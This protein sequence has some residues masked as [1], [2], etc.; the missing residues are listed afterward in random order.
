[1][2]LQELGPRRLLQPIR[3]WLQAVFAEDG[4]DRASGD[5]VIE[6][7]QSALDPVRSRRS[8]LEEIR[9]VRRREMA[10]AVT[11][12]RARRAECPCGQL[13]EIP[14]TVLAELKRRRTRIPQR[15]TRTN[16]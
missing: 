9:V 8:T 7:R 10:D 11:T 1:M 14:Q 4:G 5:L 3:R 2:G 13:R 15:S 12:T 16:R 6:I